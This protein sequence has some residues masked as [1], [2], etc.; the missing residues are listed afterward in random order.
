MRTTR[1]N[2]LL[3][4]LLACLLAALSFAAPSNAAPTEREQNRLLRR[5][6]KLAASIRDIQSQEVSQIPAAIMREAKAIIVV[7]QYEAGVIFGAAGG[8]GIVVKRSPSGEW[9]APAWLRTGEISGGLQLG[10]Q[11]LNVVL[12]V[13]KDKALEMLNRGKFQIGV[14]A[15]VVRGPT[16][17]YS[18]SSIGEDVD[19]LAYT[20]YEGYYAGATFEGG[21][22]LPDHKSNEV[23]YGERLPV[24]DIISDASLQTPVALEELF[25]LFESIETADRGDETPAAP[26]KSKD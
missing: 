23:S 22:L 7:K 25:G 16:G 9:G 21:F 20:V 14:D 12:L 18:E 10:A 4:C 1:H 19:I 3:L 15:Y 17:T 11:K 2:P 8:F 13:V 26:Q 6:E 5:G 24:A